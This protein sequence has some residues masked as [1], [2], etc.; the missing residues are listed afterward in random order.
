MNIERYEK[1]IREGERIEWYD[2][3]VPK[4][5]VTNLVRFASEGL[6]SEIDKLEASLDDLKGVSLDRRKGYLESLKNN[7]RNMPY[8]LNN[9]FSLIKK[10]RIE[11]EIEKEN[12]KKKP[13]R[14]RKTVKKTTETKE[15]TSKKTT[16]NSSLIFG[17]K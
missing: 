15:T 11:E 6:K 4:E 8:H 16:K 5:L 2:T 14:K 13:V 7:L 9:D 12:S 1:I 17:K 10:K 3:E